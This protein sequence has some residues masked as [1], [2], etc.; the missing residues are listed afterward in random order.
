M[1]IVVDSVKRLLEQYNVEAGPVGDHVKA[2]GGSVGGSAAASH[3]AWQGGKSVFNN[4]KTGLHDLTKPTPTPVPAAVA[5]KPAAVA[6]KIQSV[7]NT[8]G[9]NTM[10]DHAGHMVK[11]I[12]KAGGEMGS[13][14]KR[15]TGG[16]MKAIGDNPKVAMV[17]AG[18]AGAAALARRRALKRG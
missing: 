8:T 16:V 6:N 10:S 1:N 7:S 12:T 9:G 11:G 5:P 14:V 3:K 17:G 13:S 2:A 15:A 18:L 4:T